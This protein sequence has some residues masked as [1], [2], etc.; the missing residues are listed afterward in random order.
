MAWIAP[1]IAGWGCKHLN[2]LA[3]GLIASVVS[4]DYA[5]NPD[6]RYDVSRLGPVCA[7]CGL[8]NAWPVS[9]TIEYQSSLNIS[10][11]PIVRLIAT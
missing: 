3:T 2:V 6:L 1:F 4:P 9:P 7:I 8:V 5:A 10:G 11:V